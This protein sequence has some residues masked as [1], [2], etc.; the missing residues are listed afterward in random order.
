VAEGR[1]VRPAG[2]D[3]LDLRVRGLDAVGGTPILDIKPFM[4]E[5]EPGETRQPTWATELMRG[6]Y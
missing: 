4:R 1:H 6:Y 2:Q 3:G 5:F